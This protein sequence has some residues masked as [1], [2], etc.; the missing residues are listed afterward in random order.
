MGGFQPDPTYL[1][2]RGETR[3]RITGYSYIHR[4]GKTRICF[5]GCCQP[6]SP[7]LPHLFTSSRVWFLVQ[8]ASENRKMEIHA[9]GPIS[10][11]G[12]F[13]ATGI[14]PWGGRD[15]YSLHLYCKV[16]AGGWIR[17]AQSNSG[18][19]PPRSKGVCG[20]GCQLRQP[21]ECQPHSK[22]P[23]REWLFTS[24]GIKEGWFIFFCTKDP[25]TVWRS[26]GPPS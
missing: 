14:S 6:A 8:I 19:L 13:R 7:S 24:P 20:S 21:A 22:S 25:L 17:G 11:Q 3:G 18:L 16:A 2:N 9:L 12:Q 26:P 23:R 5:R 10:R 15:V 1:P 4:K